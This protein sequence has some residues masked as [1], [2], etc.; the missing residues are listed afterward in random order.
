MMH[1]AIGPALREEKRNRQ[2][3]RAVIETHESVAE[4]YFSNDN[5]LLSPFTIFLS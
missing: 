2:V 3:N 5:P 4:T 1:C